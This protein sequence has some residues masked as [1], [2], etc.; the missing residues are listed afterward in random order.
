MNEIKVGDTVRVSKDVPK[1]LYQIYAMS[2]FDRESEVTNVCDGLA[3]I[4]TNPI[5]KSL[6]PHQVPNQG[7]RQE[8]RV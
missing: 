4:W 6:I 7:E 3:I 5:H 2:V 8:G 1:M